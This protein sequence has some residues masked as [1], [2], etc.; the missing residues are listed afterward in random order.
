MHRLSLPLAGTCVYKD[1]KLQLAGIN[2]RA[3]IGGIWV[4]GVQR[5]SAL[6]TSET[7]TVFR[8]E[9]A[10]YYIFLQL[11]KEMWQFDDDGSVTGRPFHLFTICA[12]SADEIALARATLPSALL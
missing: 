3:R 12:S 6:V 4:D 9:S 10:K 11:S 8:S 1:Q 2:V 7:R 5:K